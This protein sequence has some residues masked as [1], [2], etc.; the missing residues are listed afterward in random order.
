MRHSIVSWDCTYRNFFHLIDGLLAQKF[1]RDE[2][3]LIFVEQRNKRESD[4]FNHGIGLR[5]LWDR[6]EEV[7]NKLNIQVV[8]LEEAREIPYHLGKC[9]NE[10]IRRSTGEIITVMDGDQLLPPNFLES[11]T[12]YH[13]KITNAVVNIHRRSALYPVGVNTFSDW[14]KAVIDFNRCLKAC[15]D[16]FS[17]LTPTVNN[18]GPMISARR[19]Y[20]EAIQGYDTGDVWASVLSKSGLDVNVRLEIATIPGRAIL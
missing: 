12:N 18:M 8:F 19:Q 15:P 20:W 5:S 6:Y 11:L 14:T 7:K 16:R 4:E 17:P 3:E 2:Y 10:G 1:P 9:N 13:E